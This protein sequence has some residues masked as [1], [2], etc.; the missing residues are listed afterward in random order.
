MRFLD[1][2]LSLW[3]WS[4]RVITGG[5]AQEFKDYA[6]QFCGAEPNVSVGCVGHAYVETGRPWLLWV[7]RLDDLATLAHEVFHVT[8]GVLEG[9]GLRFSADSEEAFTY[10]LEAIMRTVLSAKR[11][12]WATVRPA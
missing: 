5:T 7:E 12:Q 10:T 6:K 2:D 9:R 1:V 4:G 3:K 11:R 8:C